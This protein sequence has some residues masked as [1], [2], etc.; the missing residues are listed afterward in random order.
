M[1]SLS[2]CIFGLAAICFC[3]SL[4][5]GEDIS[6]DSSIVAVSVFPGRAMVTRQANLKLKE[7][8]YRIIFPDIIPELDENSVRVTAKGSAETKLYGA[9]VKQGFVETSVS[10]KVAELEQKIQ[11]AYDQLRQ[12]N[13]QKSMLMEEKS[14]LDSIRFFSGNQM[15]KE[16]ASRIPNAAELEGLLK[17]LDSRLRENYNQIMETDNVTRNVSKKAEILKRELEQVRGAPNRIKRDIVVEVE[18]T[19]PGELEMDVSFLV[20]GASW[21]PLYDA[22]AD[23]SGGTVE[24]F[25]YGVV[26]Q[27][28]G[29]DWKNVDFSLST[30]QPSSQGAMPDAEPWLLKPYEAAQRMRFA[31]EKCA[32]LA[33][34][35]DNRTMEMNQPAAAP[36]QSEADK[37]KKADMV[38]AQPQE[39]ATSIVYKLDRKSTVKADGTAY[40]LPV[41]YQSLKGA[42]EYSAFPKK[43]PHAYLRTRVTNGAQNE[44]LSGKANIFVDGDL[45]GTSL[46]GPVS[47]S[48]DFDLYL[49]VDNNVK[50]KR[51]L[52]EKKLDDVLLGGI[53]AP[54]KKISFKYKLTVENYKSKNIKIVVFEAFPVSQDEKIKVKLLDVSLQPKDKD[55]NDKKGVWRWE[56][57]LAPKEKQEITY[58][59]SVELPRGMTVEGL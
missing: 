52:V 45:V 20:P 42:F 39:G 27:R 35:A 56:L 7:G 28:T 40:R 2:V 26:T 6:A 51:E 14:F 24:L 15:P 13:D 33:G 22:R 8:A 41:F 29:E 49:G 17:F 53:P 32:S 25:S 11:D 12:L 1:K 18:V 9:Q 37:E 31:L 21:E 3:S 34:M 4:A 30:A 36:M 23:F 46:L 38:F 57:E 58:S 48:E 5:F 43:D 59:Y 47:P 55:W 54:N 19:K 16:L 50:V 44:L 10:A